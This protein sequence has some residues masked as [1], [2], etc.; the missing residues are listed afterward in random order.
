MKKKTIKGYAVLRNGEITKFCGND[1]YLISKTKGHFESDFK[2]D[3]EI[4]IVPV[5]II[6][7]NN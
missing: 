4:K 5:E 6:I 2:G 7:N 1:W 3:K